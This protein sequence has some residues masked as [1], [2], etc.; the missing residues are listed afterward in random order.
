MNNQ[1]RMARKMA[2]KTQIQIA[3]EAGI[4]ERM[5]QEYEY[6]TCEPGVRT[7]IRI[8]DTLGVIDLRE[9]FKAPGGNQAENQTSKG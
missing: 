2:Q 3:N 1:L 7:A 4:S 9:I 6:D 5:Y 8:A